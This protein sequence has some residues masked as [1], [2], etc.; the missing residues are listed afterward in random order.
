ME[1]F[2]DTDQFDKDIRDALR[3]LRDLPG[4]MDRTI[5][6]DA[7][8]AAG[9]VVLKRARQLVKVRSGRLKRSGR[10]KPSPKR[11]RPGALV[12]FSGSKKAKTLGYH[13]TLVEKG[14][15]RTR[16]QPYL[17]PAARG[18]L[19]EQAKAAAVAMRKGIGKVIRKLRRR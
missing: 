2:I 13:A 1:I 10:V 19:S 16:A 5:H 12:I 15:I 7:S 6:Q 4:E 8:M 17:E 18:T 14:T 11:H 3:L 9:R